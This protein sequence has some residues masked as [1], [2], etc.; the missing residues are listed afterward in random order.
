MV[1]QSEDSLAGGERFG[2]SVFNPH[3]D[4]DLLPW[5]GMNTLDGRFE[6]SSR[7]A[8]PD[9]VFRRGCVQVD[10][11]PQRRAQQNH[12]R[13]PHANR[14]VF[15]VRKRLKERGIQIRRIGARLLEQ[16]FV[17]AR[18]QRPQPAW[19]AQ[20]ELDSAFTNTGMFG[21]EIIVQRDQASVRRYVVTELEVMIDLL[22]R[23]ASIDVDEGESRA[24][25]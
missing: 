25:V 14:L 1:G 2:G 4:V 17:V 10:I 5:A 21:I 12:R 23:V 3:L 9:K 8:D 11:L 13:L 15:E 19:M 18:N 20:R 6:A 22:G 16:N 7:G 24:E